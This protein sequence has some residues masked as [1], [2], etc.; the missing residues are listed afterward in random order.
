MRN[1]LEAG[2]ISKRELLSL[3]RHL[4]FAMRIIPQ[5]RSFVSR[6]LYLSKSVKKLHDMVKLDAGC[7]SELRFWS[8][9]LDE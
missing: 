2:S 7:R 1:A 4:N 8:I 6:L 9:L 3:L 5:G